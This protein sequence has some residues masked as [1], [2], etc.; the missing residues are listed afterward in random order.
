MAEPQIIPLY[1]QRFGTFAC[2]PVVFGK[3]HNAGIDGLN[4][5]NPGYG[6]SGFV[7]KGDHSAAVYWGS[8]DG[9]I[10]HA[11]PFDVDAKEGAAGY[12]LRGFNT[13]LGETQHAKGGCGFQVNGFRGLKVMVL[14]DFNQSPVGHAPPIRV[15]NPAGIGR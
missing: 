3:N 1:C 8:C 13:F 5:Q 2:R 7:I 14:D 4:L 11:R 6:A 12:F 15:R 10:N 9:A